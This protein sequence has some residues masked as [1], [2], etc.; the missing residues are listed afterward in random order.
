VLAR[1]STAE[2]ALAY[3]LAIAPPLAILF[4]WEWAG[5]AETAPR[6]ISFP[7]EIWAAFLGLAESG[8]YGD[9]VRASLVRVYLGFLIGASIGVALGLVAAMYRPVR[10]F[11]DPIVSFLYPVP[12]IAFLPVLLLMLGI[13]DTSKIALI[14]LSVF[15]PLFLSARYSVSSVERNLVWAARNMGAGPVTIFWRV[16]IPSIRPQLFGG[17]RI[18]LALAFI[19]LFAAEFIGAREGLGYLVSESENSVQFDAML[20]SIAG[21]MVLGFLSDRVLLMVRARMLRGQSLGTEEG[22]G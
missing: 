21:F 14:S 16:I 22:A 7:S 20:A 3:L 19:V 8:E 12:K 18:G 9:A 4:V 17:A 2:K 11:F 13:G 6:Y 5:R 10:D 15:F 1:S